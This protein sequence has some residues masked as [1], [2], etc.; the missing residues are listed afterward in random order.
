M[1]SQSWQTVLKYELLKSTVDKFC[2]I[3]NYIFIEEGIFKIDPR[4][5]NVALEKS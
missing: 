4:K 5:K 2:I 3:K 1:N